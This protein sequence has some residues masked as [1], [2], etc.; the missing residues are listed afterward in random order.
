MQTQEDR[1]IRVVAL[2]NLNAMCMHVSGVC[3]R[4][5]IDRV[6]PHRCYVCY[7]NPDEYGI[8]DPVTAVFPVYPSAWP[9]DRGGNPRVVLDVLRVENDPEGF[10]EFSDLLD[11][12]EM[13]CD[14]ETNTWSTR[15]YWKAQ[16]ADKA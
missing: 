11:A 1:P 15:E 12:P 3:H 4:Y 5:W 10:C 9:Q 16:T 2:R 14:P 7:S 6:S 13:F 8:D